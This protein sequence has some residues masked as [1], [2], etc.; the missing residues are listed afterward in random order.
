[1]QPSGGELAGYGYFNINEL[2]AKASKRVIKLLEM[3]TNSQMKMR[4]CGRELYEDDVPPPQTG[5]LHQHK[6][7]N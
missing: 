4:S 6:L 1:M 5:P 2:I 3:N 7:N